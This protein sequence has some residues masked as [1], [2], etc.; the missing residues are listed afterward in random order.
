MSFTDK[1]NSGV[2]CA[3]RLTFLAIALVSNVIGAQEL[4]EH[5]IDP[6][7]TDSQN[8]YFQSA[9]QRIPL[10]GAHFSTSPAMQTGVIPAGFDETSADHTKHRPPIYS[11]PARNTTNY[12]NPAQ[13]LTTPTET[14]TLIYYQDNLANSKRE[15][16][17]LASNQTLDPIWIRKPIRDVRI[18]IREKA[19]VAPRDRSD[20][21]DYGFGDWTHFHGEQKVFAWYAP[22]IRYQPLYFEDVA[23][24][25]YGQTMGFHRQTLRSACHFFKS[26]LF[27]PNQVRHDCPWSCDY[28]LGFCRPGS[29]TEFIQQ[30]HYLGRPY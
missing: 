19:A 24:E 3:I 6:I 1:L 29:A 18:D 4:E 22:N 10:D 27:L 28:P 30:R 11:T 14:D 26:G 2:R 23:L 8:S 9:A 12:L 20:E 13:T 17:G 16:P 5:L 15:N 25:R 7:V 21:L